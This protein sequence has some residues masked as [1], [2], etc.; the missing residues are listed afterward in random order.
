MP[1]RL[2]D[3][4]E[5]LLKT[6]QGKEVNLASLRAELGINPDTP[7][8]DGIRV[9]MFNLAT[10]KIVK[11]SGRKDGVYKV[12][13]Q[14]KPIKVFGRERRPPIMIN[15]P[16]AQDTGQELDF[17]KDI[18]CREGDMFLLSG[19][20][21]KGKTTLCMNFCGENILL[22]PAL[23][24][25]EYTTIDNEPLSRFMGRL[26]SMDW[27]EWAD[28]ETGEDNFTLLPVREDYAEHI[29]KDK[30]NIID[31]IN[32]P[33]EYFLISPVMEGIKRELGRGIAIIAIQKNPGLD[34]GRG[35]YMTKDFADCE[36]LLD[37][38]GDSEILLTVGKVK[39]YKRPVSGRMFAYSI[40]NGVKIMNFREVV[41]CPYCKGTGVAYTKGIGQ[42]PCS[43]CGGKGKIDKG[44]F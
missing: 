15:F 43:E 1:D 22:H 4:L 17:A 12:I 39:E 36:L 19:Q 34:Y 29:I 7:A 40:V 21:N 5:E 23:M 8:W 41:K 42:A 10:K 35:G 14:V 27:V 32:L 31:W 25:N 38:F 44:V 18:I 16:R 6:T 33:G 20:S 37:Q 3:K 2:S 26:D 11:P 28:K 13:A 9:L 24:G 30:I